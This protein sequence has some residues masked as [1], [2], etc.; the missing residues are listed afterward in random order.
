MMGMRLKITATVTK[1]GILEFNHQH[2]LSG[3]IYNK[4]LYVNP[5]YATLLHNRK[6]FKFFTFSW[7]MFSR[8][9]V[10]RTEQGF[11]LPLG[12]EIWFYV[13]SPDKQ[14]IK[15]LLQG[16]LGQ[17]SLAIGKLECIV[18][19]VKI[20][21]RKISKRKV[22]FETMSPIITTTLR[23]ENGKLKIFDLPPTE[24]KFYEN[25]SKN[26]LKKYNEFYKTNIEN[27]T[28]KIEKIIWV[29]SKKIKYKNLFFTG[30]LMKFIASGSPELLQMAYDAGLGE[31][32][33][34][35]FGMLKIVSRKRK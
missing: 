2:F 13:S 12:H 32:N 23:E 4:L 35:G 29:K 11:L 16:F 1:K 7:V 31:K 3:I 33:S 18:E 6:G 9:N 22:L 20:F 30:Y 8:E 25:I 19:N 15:Y 21:D 14:F 24:E 26:L 5:V 34:S 28:F 27:P 10:K 17:T